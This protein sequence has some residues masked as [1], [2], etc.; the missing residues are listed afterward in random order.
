MHWYEIYNMAWVAFYAVIT[1]VPFTLFAAARR[2]SGGSKGIIVAA[3]LLALIHL[4]TGV[5]ALAFIALALGLIL[6]LFLSSRKTALAVILVVGV[7]AVVTDAFWPSKFPIAS[8]LTTNRPTLLR[9]IVGI[10]KGDEY[11]RGGTGYSQGDPIVEQEVTLFGKYPIVVGY[12]DRL[13]D[14]RFEV[15][16]LVS[17]AAFLIAFALLRRLLRMLETGRDIA[18]LGAALVVIGVPLLPIYGFV[19]LS[20]V[21]GFLVGRYV[22]NS[23]ATHGFLLSLRLPQ[24]VL[25]SA[26]FIVLYH[27]SFTSTL[28]DGFGYSS[29]VW[30]SFNS[31]VVMLSVAYGMIVRAF[32]NREEKS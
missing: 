5:P 32:A 19:P 6:G 12:A 10:A 13:P 24:L 17:L 28:I 27:A 1:A 26:L 3:V 16:V 9:L 22:W 25:I 4:I 30:E 21:L 29:T 14:A 8:E 20:A 2:R 18:A 7:L 11:H 31:H 23:G 15:Q